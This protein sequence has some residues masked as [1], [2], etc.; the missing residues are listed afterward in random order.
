MSRAPLALLGCLLLS[1][2]G[3]SSVAS[4]TDAPDVLSTDALNDEARTGAADAAAAD[5]LAVDG[6]TVDT[7]SMDAA[8]ADTSPADLGAGDATI[9]DLGIDAPPSDRGAPNAVVDAGPDVV[10]GGSD[11]GVEAGGDATV[12]LDVPA[13]TGSHPLLDAGARFCAV[14]Q[15]YCP[16]SGA[17]GDSCLPAAT[18]SACCPGRRVVCANADAGVMCPTGTHPLLDAGARFCAAGQC[19]CPPTGAGGD[20]CLPS[21]VA[22]TCCPGRAVVCASGDAGTSCPAGTHPL[23]DAGARFCAP[24][25]CYCSTTDAC[26]PASV[27]QGCCPTAVVCY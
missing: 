1:A 20:S 3:V 14:G 12:A 18:A 21:G 11:L 22:A 4:G 5:A 7:P 16:P 23:L 15:C 10:D 27:A 17:N 2:C 19:Y 9:G 26:R 6:G 13:C 24:G 25:H 8:L